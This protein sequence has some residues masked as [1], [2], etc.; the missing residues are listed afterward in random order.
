[1]RK[2]ALKLHDLALQTFETTLAGTGGCGTV[3]A[4][5]EDTGDTCATQIYTCA[6]YE[7]C[8]EPCGGEEGPD[9]GR[10]IIVYQTS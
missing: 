1:M 6:G 9:G 10:R 4:H 5:Q 3:A 7:T 8:V 2:L